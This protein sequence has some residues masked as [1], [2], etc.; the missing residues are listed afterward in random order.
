[1]P[2]EQLEPEKVALSIAEAAELTPF[3]A[4]SLYRIAP[5]EDSP[6]TKRCGRWVTTPE[7]LKEWIETG[8]KPRSAE[9]ESPMPKPRS[10]RQSS[11]ARKLLEYE[12]SI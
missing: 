4:S 7:K 6:F 12:G 11:F 5:Q 9:V 8:P 1:M 2:V 10:R 3:S